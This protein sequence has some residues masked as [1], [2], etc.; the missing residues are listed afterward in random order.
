M[1][2]F[3]AI[4]HSYSSLSLVLNHDDL[5]WYCF[6]SVFPLTA[7]AAEEKRSRDVVCHNS[8]LDTIDTSEF[9]D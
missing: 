3:Q 5:S 8:T 4:F 1:T 6:V 7:V 9:V 2:K